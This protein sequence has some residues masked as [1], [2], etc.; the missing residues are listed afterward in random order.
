MVFLIKS[1]WL[2]RITF[3]RRVVTVAIMGRKVDAGAEGIGGRRNEAGG[4]NLGQC[5]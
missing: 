3:S 5:G 1:T 2:L 4:N